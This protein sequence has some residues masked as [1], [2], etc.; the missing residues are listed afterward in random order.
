MIQPKKDTLGNVIAMARKEER[1]GHPNKVV[2][3]TRLAHKAIGI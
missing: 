2:V 3:E 1:V